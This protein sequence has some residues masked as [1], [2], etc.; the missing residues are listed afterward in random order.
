MKKL[1]FLALV[2]AVVL[3]L[4]GC[5]LNTVDPVADANQTILSVNGETVNK[6]TVSNAVTYYQQLYTQYNNFYSQMGYSQQYPTDASSI[7]EMILDQQKDSMVARQQ[8][9]KQGLDQFTE[10]ELSELQKQ[11]E[12]AYQAQLETIKSS[13]LVTEK[14]GDELEAEAKAYAEAHGLTLDSFLEE[15]KNQKLLEKIEKSIK[16]PVTVTDEEVQAALDERVATEKSSYEAD[17]KVFGSNLNNGAV[18]YYAP[19][20]YRYVKHIL[21]NYAEED[22]AKI[23]AANTALTDA[24]AGLTSA[25]ESESVAQNAL[26]NAA[27]NADKDALQKALDTAKEATAAAQ[28]AVDAAQKAYDE[29]QAAAGKAIQEKVD[30]VYALVKAD[31]ADFDALMA[32]YGEDPG[33]KSEPGLTN[34]Y[35]VC[36]GANYVEPFLS[37]ALAL[38]NEGDVSEP[39]LT[40]YGSHIIKYVAAIPEGVRMTLEEARATLGDSLL[41]NKKTEA[42]N[43]ALDQWISEADIKS[44]PEKMGY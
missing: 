8:A 14:I 12:E 34:G 40:S 29:A 18:C 24:Q 36:E 3:M 39:V 13:A 4:S 5:T 21:I 20:G 10:E 44:Y 41:E 32:E 9:V 11:A 33:M 37:T 43:A 28:E 31:G 2:M 35:A 19:A 30:K 42:Y 7:L 1:T 38:Q 6:Q 22:A 17:L 15:A 25:E 26:D 23:T 16:D 27:D